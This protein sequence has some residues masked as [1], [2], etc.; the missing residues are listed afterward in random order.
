MDSI[1]DNLTPC[2]GIRILES[3]KFL[4]VDSE[5]LGFGFRNSAKRIQNLDNDW[6]PESSSWYLE[7][8]AWNPESLTV[9]DCLS[10]GKITTSTSPPDDLRVRYFKSRPRKTCFSSVC[11]KRKTA[12]L[13]T[14][15]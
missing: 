7:F 8:L 10:W 9:L 11:D 1:S 14:G 13:K 2:M 4:P 15:S 6:N 12:D 3:A 5:I